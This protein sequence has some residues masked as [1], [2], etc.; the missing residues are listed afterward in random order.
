VE[1]ATISANNSKIDVTWTASADA[2][3]YRCY[4]GYYY[5]YVRFTQYI[6]T[7]SLSCTFDK[8]PPFGTSS[9]TSNIS[10][11]ASLLTY[12]PNNYYYAVTAILADGETGK[13][14]VGQGKHAPYARP[15]HLE[16]TAVA[17]ATA[18]RIYKRPDFSS[19]YVWRFDIPSGTSFDDD[20]TNATA[21]DISGIPSP[22]GLLPCIHVGQRADITNIYWNAFL[23][24][25]CAVKSITSVYLGGILLDPGHFGVDF[26]VPG[27]TNFATYFG[28]TPYVDINGRRYTLLYVRGPHGDAAVSGEKPI[29]VTLEGIETV[30]DGSGTL[31]ESLADQ[32]EHFMRNLV[33]RDYQTGNWE[34]IG[35]M[36]GDTPNDVDIV[37]GV[38]FDAANA[39]WAQREGAGSPAEC[40]GAWVL[41]LGENGQ[42]EQVTVRTQLARL[43]QSLDCYGGFSRKSQYVVKMINEFA[44]ISDAP[45]FTDTLGINGDTFTVEDRPDEIENRITYRYALDAPNGV[46]AEGIVD[47][48]DAQAAIDGE[49]RP[50]TLNLWCIRAEAV[51]IEIAYRRLQR[52]KFPYRSVRWESDMGGLTVDLGDIV[53][54]SHPDGAGAVGWT[55]RPIFLTRHE[56]NPD[57][58]V[59][60][61]EGLDLGGIP[62][63]GITGPTE[64]DGILLETGDSLLMETGD[65]LLLEA[66]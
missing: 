28:A 40:L 54:V 16:W 20:L 65:E 46:W 8:V 34:T 29:T 62:L 52:R 19:S 63:G 66:T 21:I 58:F 44:D 39:V 42:L 56:F 45:K 47:D 6:E 11:G 9:T 24:A 36:W 59:V 50:Y 35:P 49:V 5:Y 51:A 23:V 48:E 57:R 7:A 25:G 55:D 14:Q 10:T 27:K 12:T 17:G 32:Y 26:A 3:T 13:S 41:G 31:I 60:E 4:I 53:K 33:L 64:G 43:N 22:A 30:G 18:Y 2:V 15:V 38:T 1:T 61:F 37:D